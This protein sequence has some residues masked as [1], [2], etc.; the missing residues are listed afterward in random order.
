MEG[1]IGNVVRADIYIAP[2]ERRDSSECQVW[3]HVTE[4]TIP[5]PF[6][7]PPNHDAFKNIRTERKWFKNVQICPS[8]PAE[9]IQNSKIADMT[10]TTTQQVATVFRP[11]HEVLDDAFA[12]LSGMVTSE[13]VMMRAILSIS[14]IT[15]LSISEL[16]E[17]C[18][19]ENK[20]SAWGVDSLM[21]LWIY[22]ELRQLGLYP[23][24]DIPSS[25]TLQEDLSNM[26]AA[27][28]LGFGDETEAYQAKQETYPFST[29]NV[30][31]R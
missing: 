26:V 25:Y 15:G 8:D 7:L 18:K 28:V 2:T 11:E 23:T 19:E 10:S 13:H 4:N 20:L 21:S 29:T 31:S 27:L 5:Q 17:A 12:Y 30:I 1:K 14:E 6:R 24:D 3:F 16:Q 22:S 9:V